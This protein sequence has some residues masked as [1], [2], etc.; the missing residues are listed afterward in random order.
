[1]NRK[2]DYILTPMGASMTHGTNTCCK[3]LSPGV[4]VGDFKI[5]DGRIKK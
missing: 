1:M 3:A 5:F 4:Q 2:D